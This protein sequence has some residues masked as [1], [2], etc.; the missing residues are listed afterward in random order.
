M[1]IHAHTSSAARTKHALCTYIGRVLI[2]LFAHREVV[3]GLLS[4]VTHLPATSTVSLKFNG[5]MATVEPL[6]YGH[7]WDHIKCPD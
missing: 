4:I 6:Y 5:L 1:Y 7:L 2:R 3:N